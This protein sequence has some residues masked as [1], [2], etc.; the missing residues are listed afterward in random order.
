LRLGALG[1]P[2][3]FA[4][5]AAERFGQLGP[6]SYF[7]SAREEWQALAEGVIDAFVMLAES[8]RT[9]F[10]ELARRA[11]SPDAGFFVMGE[12]QVPYGCLLLTRPGTRLAEVRRV[13]GHGSVDQCRA[14][15]EERLAGVEVV[16]EA[17]SSVEAAAQLGAGEALV[18]TAQTAA[19]FGLEVLARD[20][21]G[22]VVGNYWMV[23]REPRFAERP[24][25]VLASG[26][27]SDGLSDVIG[28][29]AS[30]GFGLHNLLAVPSG[31]R[32]FEYDYLLAFT[33]SGALADVR[34]IGGV[35]LVGAFS[36]TMG[37]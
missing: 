36:G 19:A 33:G 14:W 1:G 37:D 22:G 28:E 26:R 13:V 11:A 34:R 21:D 4:A 16:Q 27:L 18:G 7:A 15:L 10:G 32:L 24:S 29:F 3:T 20:I 6:I 35:R 12:A 2:G 9:G 5:Q 17:C 23:S 30:V 31:E 8:S 25:T